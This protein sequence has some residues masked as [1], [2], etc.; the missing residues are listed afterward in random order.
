MYFV[1][2]INGWLEHVD[3]VY[4]LLEKMDNHSVNTRKKNTLNPVWDWIH[5][6]L[7]AGSRSHFEYILDICTSMYMKK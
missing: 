3:I 1:I 7:V 5:V 6:K 4:I 2:V